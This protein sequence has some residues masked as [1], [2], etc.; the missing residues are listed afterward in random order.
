MPKACLGLP[1]RRSQD[2]GT[3]QYFERKTQFHPAL[4][5]PALACLFLEWRGAPA[6]ALN[7]V[8]NTPT[9]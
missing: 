9:V 1:R 8:C 7:P 6:S 3:N 5:L 4:S 2:G